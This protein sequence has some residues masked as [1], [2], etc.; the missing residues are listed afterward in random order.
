MGVLFREAAALRAGEAEI[1]RVLGVA[2]YADGAAILD[3][4]E[5]PAVGVAE[6]TNRGMGLARH[7]AS[8]SC[9]GAGEGR[10]DESQNERAET[11]Q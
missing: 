2:L 6:A 4:D 8:L 5:D 3:L 7:F 9:A 11:N 1:G 10:G